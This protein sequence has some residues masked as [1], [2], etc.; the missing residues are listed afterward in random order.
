V[1]RK[2]LE[3]AGQAD[4]PPNAPLLRVRRHSPVGQER[5][6][7]A[8]RVGFSVLRIRLDFIGKRCDYAK[9]SLLLWCLPVPEALKTD[10]I[11]GEVRRKKVTQMTRIPTKVPGLSKQYRSKL[12]E[13]PDPEWYLEQFRSHIGKIHELFKAV[14]PQQWKALS[15]SIG[16]ALARVGEKAGVKARHYVQTEDMSR[17]VKRFGKVE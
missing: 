16:D 1:L 5:T 8:R 11:S 12:I 3:P 2:R 13:M 10:L 15:L 17:K 6:P 14:P 4:F 7:P 9:L